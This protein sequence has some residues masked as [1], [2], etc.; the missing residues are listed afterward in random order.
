MTLMEHLSRALEYCDRA[1][2]MAAKALPPI[3]TEGL[4]RELVLAQI[5][6]VRASVEGMIAVIKLQES[7]SVK[8][9]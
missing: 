8:N 4:Q 6:T 9:N 5:E 2:V 1:E 3:S 7:Q